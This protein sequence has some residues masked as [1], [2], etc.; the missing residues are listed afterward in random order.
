LG[1]TAEP[2]DDVS[3]HSLILSIHVAAGAIALLA[4]WAA[5]LQRKGSGGHRL[6]GRVFLLAMAPVLVSG[7]PLAH[8]L[9]VRGEAL[10]AIFL[11]FLLALL[12]HAAW[13]AWRAVRDRND[14]QRFFGPGYW[15]RNGVVGVSGMAVLALG[16]QAGEV[17]MVIF[18]GVGGLV[19]IDAFRAWRRSAAPGWWLR[20][21][22]EGMLGCGVGTHV[23]FIGIGL[24]R[25]LPDVDPQ[26]LQW[27]AWF[28][29]LVAAAAG[30]W[31][32]NRRYRRRL[33]RQ[34][35]AVRPPSTGRLTPL[36]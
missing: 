24:H 19:A 27:L 10:F 33:P 17:L 22:Y 26:L 25:V 1:E 23:A 7:V 4:F 11:C 29:P 16:W 6:A 21:H 34:S 5:M 12:A 20:E 2:E 9:A 3:N 15:L 28:G 35:E 32:L 8:L 36:M 14:R 18:G 13:S 31:W 30:G